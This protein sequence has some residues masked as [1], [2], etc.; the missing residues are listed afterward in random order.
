MDIKEFLS[1][2]EKQQKPKNLPTLLEALWYDGTG[3]WTKAHDLVDGM[4]G[5]EAAGIHAYLHRKEGDQWNANYWYRRAG[6]TMPLLSL[7]D[8][9]RKLVEQLL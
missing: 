7:E 1:S 2:V 3:N 4:S 9:W 5:V 8:E 6:R